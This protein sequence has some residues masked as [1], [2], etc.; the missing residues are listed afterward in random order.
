MM[1]PGIRSLTIDLDG[2]LLD[3]LPDLAAAANAMLAELGEPERE[4]EEIRSFVG[5]GIVELVRRAL[6]EGRD[7]SLDQ[8]HA[9]TVFR[10]HYTLAN[11]RAARPFPGV[12][13]GLDKL[14]ALGL[15][16]A[17]VTNKAMEFTEPLLQ[18]T[19]LASYFS[20]TLGG[21][22]LAEKKPHPMPLLHA[23]QHMDSTPA[24]NLHVG[25]SRHDA[26]A[27]RAAGCPVALVPYGYSAGA[28]VHKLDCDVIV[29]SLAE[30][31]DL[32]AADRTS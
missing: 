29:A 24:S 20:L 2:T 13:E 8:Q 14:K 22:S 10:R 16:M 27:A 19:G 12:M 21:D 9:I 1:F 3:S 18:I 30:L 32:I 15:P 11:G 28:D 7:C 31:A 4:V 26:E 23:A 6:T 25:D 5:K 17:V